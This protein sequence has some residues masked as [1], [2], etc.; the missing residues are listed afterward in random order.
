MTDPGGLFTLD[1]VPP[2]AVV[3]RARAQSPDGPLVGLASVVLAVESAQDVRIEVREPGKVRGR[4]VAAGGALP[5]GLR[6]S[7]VPTLLGPSVL[8]PAEAAAVDA[9]GAFEV[10]GSV[11]EHAVVIGGLPAGWAVRRAPSVWLAAGATI[12]GVRVE[13]APDNDK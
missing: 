3:L 7:L 10:T 13:I 9:A 4:V 2:G 8:Y 11:G 6:V 12:D 5:A 1:R